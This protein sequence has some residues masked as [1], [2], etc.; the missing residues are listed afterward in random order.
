MN[1]DAVRKKERE[2]KR[3]DADGPTDRQERKEESERW[4]SGGLNR[5]NS[6]LM[7]I[8]DSRQAVRVDR[9]CTS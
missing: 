2:R 3:Y 1:R 6:L 9:D 4:A 7:Q 8:R 5:R